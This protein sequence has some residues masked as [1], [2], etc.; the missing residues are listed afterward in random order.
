MPISNVRAS[1]LGSTD[2]LS[3]ALPEKLTA[4][5]CVNP[6]SDLPS[7][8]FCPAGSTSKVDFTFRDEFVKPTSPNR[9]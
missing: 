8:G 9:G 2:G 7:N 1:N 5:V 3:Q 4:V 6:L